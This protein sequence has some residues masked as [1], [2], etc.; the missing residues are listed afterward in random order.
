[1]NH[2][3]Y[4]PCGGQTA[5]EHSG[6]MQPAGSASNAPSEPGSQFAC[7]G[8]F[9][10]GMKCVTRESTD[11]Y[12]AIAPHLKKSLDPGQVDAI[13]TKAGHSR[14]SD[15]S[16]VRRGD[17]IQLNGQHTSAVDCWTSFP[18]STQSSRVCKQT[19]EMDVGR[20]IV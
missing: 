2:L 16:G 6:G 19:R 9:A 4:D 18:C 5:A 15:T 12:R 10:T 14:K 3:L 7:Q 20:A 1:M 11:R 13:N 8:G 17:M